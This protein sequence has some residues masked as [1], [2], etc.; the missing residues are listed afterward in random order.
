MPLEGARAKRIILAV[1]QNV[2]NWEER[3]DEIAEAA[4]P[5]TG[6]KARALSLLR[7]LEM[8]RVSLCR[9]AEMEGDAICQQPAGEKPPE[10]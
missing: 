10:T 1:L 6:N 5:V 9:L 4:I 2:R 8:F 7:D 3:L